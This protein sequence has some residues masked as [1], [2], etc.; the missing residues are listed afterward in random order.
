MSEV[1]HVLSSLLTQPPESA[2]QILSSNQSTADRKRR[3][4]KK[5]RQKV[6]TAVKEK[7]LLADLDH[8]KP[9][10]STAEFEKGLTKIATKG[11]L[12]LS[13]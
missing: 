4:E 13:F 7:R 5:E 9:D 10:F 11:G 2:K 12:F 1:D 6:R 3:R 8:I